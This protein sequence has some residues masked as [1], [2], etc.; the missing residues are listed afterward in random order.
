MPYPFVHIGFGTLVAVN[1]IVTMLSPS[2]LPIRRLKEEAKEQGRLID[3]TQGR[4][5]RTVIVM[6]SDH[7]ILSTVAT[8]T[9]ANRAAGTENEL[10]TKSAT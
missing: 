10:E 8:E 6:D 1:R 2:S 5:T 3:A 9:I 4:R 7:I